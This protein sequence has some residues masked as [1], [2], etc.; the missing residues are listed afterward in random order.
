MNVLHVEYKLNPFLHT[1]PALLFFSVEIYCI[2]QPH[3]KVN[4]FYTVSCEFLGG[5][6]PDWCGKG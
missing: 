6:M 5:G 2:S 4:S 3:F 1:H